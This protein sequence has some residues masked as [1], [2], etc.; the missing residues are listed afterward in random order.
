ME[1]RRA[2]ACENILAVKVGTV[3]EIYL[4][5]LTP[6]PEIFGGDKES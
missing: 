2:N 4:I 5:I 6:Y 3:G 1:R